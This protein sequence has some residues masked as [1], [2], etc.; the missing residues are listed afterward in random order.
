[1]RRIRQLSDQGSGSG[2]NQSSAQAN[3]EAP[4]KKHAKVLSAALNASAG[5]DDKGTQQ[6]RGPPA[7]FI[8]KKGSERQRNNATDRLHVD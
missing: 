3:E 6:N 7:K 4:S 5:D 2:C 1:M 8:G